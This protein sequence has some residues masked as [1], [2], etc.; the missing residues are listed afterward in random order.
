MPKHRTHRY[1]S[2]LFLGKPFSEVHRL[3]D[4]PYIFLGRKHRQ[5]FHTPVEA[6]FMGCSASEDPD[7]GMAG[8]LHVW[9]DEMCSKDKKFKKQLELLAKYA[10]MNE[11]DLRY[12]ERQSRKTS[13]RRSRTR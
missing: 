5:M 11:R 6:Y 4:E 10:Q 7:A 9:L 13:R 8:F 1:V 2:R 3:I 12:L